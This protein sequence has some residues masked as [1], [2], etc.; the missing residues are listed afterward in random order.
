MN[1]HE[2]KQYCLEHAG[3][4]LSAEAEAL[5]RRDPDLKRQ[6]DRL[7]AVKNLVSLKRYEQP[8]PACLDRCLRGVREQVA[9]RHESVWDRLVSL[10]E[11]ERP[12]LAYGM[13]ALAVAVVG[14]AVVLNRGGLDVPS[15]VQ[16][17]PQI[18]EE[19]LT[20]EPVVFVAEAVQPEEPTIATEIASAESV[21]PA[22]NKPIIF[23]RTDNTNIQP[24][25]PRMQIN[26]GQV[27]PV[28]F[29]Y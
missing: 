4:D 9:V 20:P 22:F 24:S 14:S 12:A 27:V 8:D 19:S 5:L 11:F 1:E 23:L 6:V 28:S 16:N 7:V 25:T 18:S 17:A 15:I 10:F 13:A 26:G 21:F 29:E 2:L 3:E